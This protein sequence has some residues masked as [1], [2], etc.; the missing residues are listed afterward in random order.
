[1][2]QF[3]ACT[4]LQFRLRPILGDDEY[5]DFLRAKFGGNADRCGFL[6]AS[7]LLKVEE[8]F[9]L[10]QRWRVPGSGDINRRADAAPTKIN[11]VAKGFDVSSSVF[12]NGYSRVR[13]PSNRIKPTSAQA[14]T[15]PISWQSRWTSAPRSAM[16]PF[17]RARPQAL[18]NFWRP[19]AIAHQEG[20]VSNVSPRR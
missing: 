7:R 5:L 16:S 20:C 12:P 13:F 11:T 18:R 8:P 19:E 14:W 4:I 2:T 6:Y 9:D 17:R 1:M 10:Q 15:H 3:S